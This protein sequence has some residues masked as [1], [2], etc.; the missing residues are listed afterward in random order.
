MYVCT[1][2]HACVCM[3]EHINGKVKKF[4]I[5]SRTRKCTPFLSGA[6]TLSCN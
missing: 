3:C 5:P 4:N 6:R 2:V 1:D